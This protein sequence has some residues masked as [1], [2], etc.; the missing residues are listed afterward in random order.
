MLGATTDGLDCS[1]SSSS[2]WWWCGF[3]FSLHLS[4]VCV[5]HR[6]GG[7]GW[8]QKTT[9]SPLTNTSTVVVVSAVYVVQFLLSAACILHT[10]YVLLLCTLHYVPGVVHG[11]TLLQHVLH[12]ILHMYTTHTTYM[13]CPPVSLAG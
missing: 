1:S 3:F 12:D 9:L 5:S 8:S 10:A 2:S 4:C 7:A 6:W 11:T 13:A